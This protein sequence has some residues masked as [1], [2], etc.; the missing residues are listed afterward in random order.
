EDRDGYAKGRQKADGRTE[1]RERSSRADRPLHRFGSK[2]LLVV[3][4]SISLGRHFGGAGGEFRDAGFDRGRR[5][6]EVERCVQAAI[7]VCSIAVLFCSSEGGFHCIDSL[8]MP[9]KSWPSS[10]ASGGSFSTPARS[11]SKFRTGVASDGLP[12]PKNSF[13][14]SVRAL[15]R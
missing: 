15:L 1:Y 9:A 6:D 11:R 10:A 12:L 14:T 5:S 13:K 3:S 2:T 4:I 8:S 7:R